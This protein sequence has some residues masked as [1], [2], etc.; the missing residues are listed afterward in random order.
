MAL[1][2]WLPLNGTLDNQGF[3]EDVAITNNGAAIDNGIYG[4]C[5]SFNGTSLS[6]SNMFY[7]KVKEF[8][9]CAWVKLLDG[10]N[11][12]Y[13]CHL[14][15]IDNYLR[16]CISK[17]GHAIGFITSN[18]ISGS[19]LDSAA[20]NTNKWYHFAVTFYK[21]TA[22]FYIN[23]QLDSQIDVGVTTLINTSI[24]YA[25][26][27]NIGSYSVEKAVACINDYRIYDN[28][29]SSREIKEISKGLVCH[30][31]MGDV[32]GY[33][34]GRNLLVGTNQGSSKWSNSHQSGTYL[35]ESVD[36]LNLN[37]VKMTCVE[38]TTGWKM[39]TYSGLISNFE[40]LEPNTTYTLSY[41]TNGSAPFQN[42]MDSSAVNSIIDSSVSSYTETLYGRHYRVQIKTKSELKK[43][44]QVVYFFN[45]LN[46]DESV[47]IANLKL[48]KGV[49]DTR[50]I[51]AIEDNLS[52]FDKSIYDISGYGY[53]G[54]PHIE[55]ILPS[56][57]SPRYLSSI[58]FNGTTDYISLINPITANN[59]FT[60]SAWV[61]LD[62][63][64]NNTLI[65][66]RITMGSGISLF[67]LPE[68]IRF[69]DGIHT[70]YSFNASDNLN[71]WFHICAVR[72]IEDSSKKIYIN[73]ALIEQTNQIDQIGNFD[74]LGKN[75]LIGASQNSDTG[76]ADGN[77]LNGKIVDF[78]IYC[79]ALSES[80]IKDLYKVPASLSNNGT[81][82]CKGEYI[83]W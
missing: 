21:G 31:P 59:S 73:G 47:I 15:S 39:F 14:I 50:W 30:Y 37:A 56:N 27:F 3:D 43:S 52:L 78:R 20:L 9:V 61:Y 5:Y 70:S 36:W 49:K 69:D 60:I 75:F 46:N 53:N 6:V 81:L 22:S 80:D 17:D 51:P 33:Y 26:T 4:K 41:D 62:E 72:N 35:C 82:L 16:I 11:L 48:E 2:V 29:L 24:D 58:S 55:S 32:D 76:V 38:K 74:G 45:G 63:V 23:G 28:T 71:K 66:S 65:C 42:L 12:N 13:G 1:Q 8:T 57:I 79:S 83:E 64:R 7:N 54:T 40:K 77:Y 25:K 34:I 10:Y 68:S 67:I 44:T 18:I 19:T